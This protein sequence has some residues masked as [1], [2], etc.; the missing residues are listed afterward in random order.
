VASLKFELDW[1]ISALEADLNAK[2]GLD[3]P[4][5][6]ADTERLRE[7][8]KKREDLRSAGEGSGK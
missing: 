5:P 7:L 3:Q 4:L 1:E 2:H 6:K 8:K